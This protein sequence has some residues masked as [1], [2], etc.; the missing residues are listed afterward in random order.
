MLQA[1]ISICDSTDSSVI[2]FVFQNSQ[3]NSEA[4]SAS[5]SLSIKTPSARMEGRGVHE[6]EHS[7]LFNNKVKNAWSYALPTIRLHSIYR[8]NFTFTCF[9]TIT[10]ISPKNHYPH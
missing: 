9:N 1:R 4:H 3:T 7:T 8:G 10:L 6:V 5:Y 2:I